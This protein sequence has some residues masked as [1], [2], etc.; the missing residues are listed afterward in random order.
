MLAFNTRLHGHSAIVAHVFG[1]SPVPISQVLPMTFRRNGSGSFGSTLTVQMPKVGPDWGYVT[2]F[3]LTL[4][5]RYRYRGRRLSLLSASCPGPQGRAQGTRSRA[6]RG[7]YE[8]A[9]GQDPDPRPERNL[10]GRRLGGG[11]AARPSP[12]ARAKASSA[13]RKGASVM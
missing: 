6:A 1:K 13:P 5:R 9:G 10:Q 11:F 12:L 7:T 2:G 4:K 3:D 8:L